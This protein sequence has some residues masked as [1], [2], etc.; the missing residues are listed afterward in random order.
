MLV[1]F[2]TALASSTIAFRGGYATNRAPRNMSTDE[3]QARFEDAYS[4]NAYD[5]ATIRVANITNDSD[6]GSVPYPDIDISVKVPDGSEMQVF[7]FTEW[8]AF[9]AF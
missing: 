6:E 2:L 7:D 1:H 5:S 8:Q 9:A 4:F 3:W